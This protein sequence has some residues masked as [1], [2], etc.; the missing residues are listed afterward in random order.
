MGWDL[1]DKLAT[2]SRPDTDKSIKASSQ[3]VHIIL[4]YNN[5]NYII[6]Q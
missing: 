1:E 5:L 2:C 6:I 4:F 3:N